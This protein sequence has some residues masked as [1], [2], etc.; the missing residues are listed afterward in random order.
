MRFLVFIFFPLSVISFTS[1]IMNQNH[2]INYVVKGTNKY[3]NKFVIK[4]DVYQQALLSYYKYKDSIVFPIDNTDPIVKKIL[5]ETMQYGNQERKYKIKNNRFNSYIDNIYSY[6]DIL[7]DNNYTK[8]KLQTFFRNYDK[9]T[10]EELITILMLIDN[11]TLS[12]IRE[13]HKYTFMGFQKHIRIIKRKLSDFI[14]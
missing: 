2:L 7:I 8:M 14:I 9:F 1:Q 13:Y 12:Q 3:M 5:R 4:D 11:K 10:K 6:E